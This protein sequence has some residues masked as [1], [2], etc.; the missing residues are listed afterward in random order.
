[1][2]LTHRL[3][4]HVLT[5]L[6]VGGG[7]YIAWR[8]TSLLMFRWF[9]VLGFGPVVTA[10]RAAAC[11]PSRVPDFV[12]FTVPDGAWVYAFT[13]CLAII[14]TRPAPWVALP[15]ALGVGGELGQAAGIVPGVFDARDMAVMTA[16][17]A[18]AAYFNLNTGDRP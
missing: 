6:L 18:L 17:A 12:R 13:A 8:S 14:W 9:E 5:P 10:V 11:D 2:S 3:T 16:G 15:V 4:V 1:M 7:I